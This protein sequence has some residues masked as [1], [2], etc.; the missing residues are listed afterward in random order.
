MEKSDKKQKQ[1]VGVTGGLLEQD[2]DLE[3]K[4]ITEDM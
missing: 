1:Y 3:C 4:E 2:A